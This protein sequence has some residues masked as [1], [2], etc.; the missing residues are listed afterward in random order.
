MITL[1]TE[2]EGL[3]NNSV[4][5]LLED[6]RGNLWFGTYG[7]GVNMVRS[8]YITHFTEREG[9]SN[10]IVQSLLE[11]RNGNIWVSTEKGLNL[12]VFEA[13]SIQDDTG[14]P[15]IRNYGLQDGLKGMDFILNSALLD[16]RN[17]IWWGSSKSL[18][19]VDMN[20][21]SINPNLV[22][23]DRNQPALIKLLEKHGLDVIPLK[24]RHSKMLG[25][26]PH[27]VTVD[28]RR[29]GTLQRYFD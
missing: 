3:S 15:K 26:G 21:F 28:I 16:R 23:V 4:L 13:N 29:S 9:L 10:N 2:K 14:Y 19:M 24:L 12:L 7:G 11:D 8:G 25:G 1:F 5:S 27:C 20:A 18:T 6:K 17:R 22:V